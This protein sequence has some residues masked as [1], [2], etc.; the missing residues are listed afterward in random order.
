ME[1][2]VEKYST[3]NV[4]WGISKRL[5]IL[6]LRLIT[7][8][9]FTSRKL[10]K[11]RYKCSRTNSE[12]WFLHTNRWNSFRL[13]HFILSFHFADFVSFSFFVFAAI[14]GSQNLSDSEHFN[15]STFFSFF[16]F[17]SSHFRCASTK[18]TI[19]VLELWIL[20]TVSNRFWI[21]ILSMYD[22]FNFYLCYFLDSHKHDSVGLLCRLAHLW[23]MRHPNKPLLCPFGLC[24]WIV[25]LILFD[26]K[27]F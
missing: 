7:F 8:S 2:N 25:E 13:F 17:T 19:F 15:S 12:K 4:I 24:C 11:S 27:V 3:E 5:R 10:T 26:R 6:N 1:R 22:F 16:I 18:K 20:S 14:R 21:W 9:L 23:L